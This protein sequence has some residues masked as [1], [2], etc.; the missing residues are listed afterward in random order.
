M[1]YQFKFLLSGDNWRGPAI[2][3]IKPDNAPPIDVTVTAARVNGERQ[4]VTFSTENKPARVVVSLVNDLWGE[5]A[6]GEDR[7]AYVESAEVNG[8]ALTG[9][10]IALQDSGAKTIDVP[11]VPPTSDVSASSI[12]QVAGD[13]L[14]P[15][16]FAALSTPVKLGIGAAVVGGLLLLLRK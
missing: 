3:R 1:A 14:T 13:A 8:Y 4:P 5:V 10:P 16:G 11:Y 12:A 15:S 7:N 2:V 9:A 6:K